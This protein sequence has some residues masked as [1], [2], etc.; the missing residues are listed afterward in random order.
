MGFDKPRGMLV[1]FVVLTISVAGDIHALVEG[2]Y[3]TLLESRGV[4]KYFGGLATVRECDMD[5]SDGEGRTVIG[6]NVAGKTHR[7]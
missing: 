3:M 5:V 7:T 1:W 4:P 2:G 6:P